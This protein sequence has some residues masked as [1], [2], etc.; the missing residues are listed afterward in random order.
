MAAT[1]SKGPA[2][3][4]APPTLAWYAWQAAVRAL[5]KHE[6]TCM[7]CV[8][9]R[10]CVKGRDLSVAEVKAHRAVTHPGEA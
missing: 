7:Q 2:N 5:R 6:R 4:P 1:G 9:D 10:Y 8:V 3:L